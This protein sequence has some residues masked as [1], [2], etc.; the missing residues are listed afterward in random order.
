[1]EEVGLLAKLGINW[2]LLLSQVVNF[3]ILLIILRSFVYKPLLLA[4]KKRNEKIKE[5]LDK[6]SE[7]TI[8]LK[9]VDIVAKNKLNQAE[10]ESLEIIKNTELK[11]REMEK[12]LYRQVENR[13]SEAIKQIELEHDRKKEEYQKEI[14]REAAELIKK[15]I[16]KTV[17]LSP[18]EIDRA[19]IKQ[20]VAEIK[21]K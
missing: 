21:E 8:R 16:V 1:M 7:A 10:N 2:K 13:R 14:F 19:L 18:N 15:I 9:E 11:A 3:L 12:N 20:A 6:A 5:G 4:I 17:E